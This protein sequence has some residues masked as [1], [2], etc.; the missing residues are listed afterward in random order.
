[1][2]K[3]YC[4]RI[5]RADLTNRKLSWEEP[6]EGFYRR[7]FGGAGLATYYLLKEQKP[8]TDPW[9]PDARL[10]FA[11]GVATGA[12]VTGVGRH[13]VLAR[14]PMTE[15]V[16]HSESGGYWGAELKHAGVDAIV[17]EGTSER[18]VYLWIHDGEAE[19]RDA[20]ELWGLDTKETEQAL[21]RGL[22]DEKIRV[23]S[24]GRAGEKLVRYACVINDLHDASG[25]TGMGSVMGS[26]RLKAIAIR[27]K[28]LLPLGN[29]EK[30]KAVAKWAAANARALEGGMGIYGTG[31][32]VVAYNLAGNLPSRNFRDGYFEGAEKI[33]A[34]VLQASR[35]IGMETCYACAVRCKKVDSVPEGPYYADPAYGGP[36]YETLGAFGSNCGI[37]NLDAIVHANH[38][39]N[40]Y[41]I[42]T[43]SAGCTIAFAME[44]YERGLLSLADT[45]GIDLRF[46]NADGMIAVLEKIARREGIGD[47]LAEGVKRA[48]EKIGGGSDAFAV[49]V[50]GLEFGMHEPRLKFALGLG[51]ATNAHGGDHNLGFHD[52]NY[53]KE[54]TSGWPSSGTASILEMRALG[55]QEVLPANDLS[56]TKVGMYAAGH[57]WRS[58][59]DCLVMCGFMPYTHEQVVQI[60]EGVTGWD[61]NVYELMKVGERAVTLMR[62]FNAREGFTAKDDQL[63]PRS[64]EP[65]TRGAL[66]NQ[67]QDRAMLERAKRDYYT[68]MGWDV[69]TGAPTSAKLGELGI[70]WV[71]DELE[72]HGKL[73]R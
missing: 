73:P 39:C 8:G 9:S 47:L 12:P 17:V 56:A 22:G 50:K 66:A 7:Y 58:L 45:D 54:K 24:I 40:A 72:K 30:L 14:S 42:D 49:H 62:A 33:T 18:P 52:T 4:D 60:V 38:L 41:G 1:M 34:Q 67:A 21:R 55:F 51:Y 13:S 5:L 16:G 19:V 29:G 10:I 69:E 48:A 57:N 68:L 20:S 23:A 63:P 2:G 71:A 11:A 27:G 35:G 44:C 36:E 26:K 70:G 28:G 64:F 25:R 15:T 6:G 43:I 37:D 59:Q 31:S 32:G 46:G 61:T 53:D 65:T 3:G